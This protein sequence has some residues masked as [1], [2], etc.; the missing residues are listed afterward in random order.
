MNDRTL[1][2]IIRVVTALLLCLWP[3]TSFVSPRLLASPGSSSTARQGV[4]E[5]VEPE[6]GV[7]VRLIGAMH[8][9]PASIRLT[10]DALEELQAQRRLGSVL[11]ESCPS[12][13]NATLNN[14]LP[15][16][17]IQLLQSEMRTAHDMALGYDR[18][19]ILGDQEI[20]TTVQR[21]REGLAST[22]RAVITPSS[23]STLTSNITSS[24]SVAVPVGPQYLGP[25]ALLDPKLVLA[26]PVSFFKYPL[27]YIVKDPFFALLVVGLIWGADFASAAVLGQPTT[28]L[29]STVKVFQDPTAFEWTWTDAILDLSG[30]A[31][32]TIVFANLFLQVLLVERNQVLARNIL[33]QCRYY[34]TSTS[35]SLPTNARKWLPPW[36][37]RLGMNLSNNIPYAETSPAPSR[38]EGDNAVVVAVLG[39][40]HVNG[41]RKILEDGAV[42]E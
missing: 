13:W 3:A 12:R 33:Q 41:V 18:P 40:A 9:N 23:W 42:V 27:S 19:V 31:L 36:M 2:C 30:S 7:T 35:T 1:P 21:L 26:A 6:T 34:Q 39:M 32:E 14:D 22:V 8:Y 38:P 4:L 17:V 11:I 10:E 29:D 25:Q 15:S 20:E 28:V 16:F 37:R 5:F 24:W